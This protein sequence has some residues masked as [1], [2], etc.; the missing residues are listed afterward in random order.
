MSYSNLVLADRP[1]GY[2]SG[3]SFSRKNLLSQ[4]QYSLETSTAGWSALDNS[5]ISRV[6][7]DAWIGTASLQITPS[8]SSEAGFKIA[9]GS[10]VQLS[11]GRTYTM[12][13]RVKNTSGSRTARIRVE[14]FTTQSG[15][16]L[17]EPTRLGREFDISNSEWTTIYNTEII[18]T[19]TST[20]YFASWGIVSGPG[21]STDQ[22]LVDGIQF[23]EGPP[24]AIYDQQYNND[25][26]L[27]YL[28]YKN[29]KPIIFN[30]EPAI[31]LSKDAI[32]EIPNPYKLFISGAESKTA[33]VD[34]WFTLEKPPAYRHQLIKISQFISCYIENDKIYIDYLG[35]K[36]FVQINNWS[37]Q[38]YVNLVY[39]EKTIY[40]YVD[41]NLSTFIDLGSDFSFDRVSEFISPTVVIGPASEPVNKIDNPSFEQGVVGWASL[42]SSIQSISS[43]SFSG[44][45]CLEITKQSVNNSGVECSNLISVN[46]YS[47]YSLS[48]YIKIPS[49]EE[50][51]TL[52]LICEEYDSYS[53]NNLI[54]VSEE[55]LEILN[56]NWS[57]LSLSFVP[58]V[59]TVAV[60]IKIVQKSSGVESER[61]LCD[62]VLLEKSP[63][64]STWSETL[65]DSDPLFIS[66]IGLY[67]HDI[68]DQRRLDRFLYASFDNDDL[69][70]IE[71]GADRFSLNYSTALSESEI[72]VISSENVLNSSLNNIVYGETSLSTPLLSTE[73]VDIGTSG[74]DVV[75]NRKGIKFSGSAFLPL[76]Q[77]NNYLNP[78]SSTIRMQTLF[79]TTSGDGT[80][81]LIGGV[82]SSYGVALQKI[83]NKL[84]LVLISDPLENIQV[85]C[86]TT[87]LSN[88]LKNIAINLNNRMISLKVDSQEFLDIEIP[89][90]SSSGGLVVG[91]LPENSNAYPDY[92]RNFSV[93]ELTD[94]SNI[95]WVRTG[96]YM[97]RFNGSL[98]VSQR[99]DFQYSSPEMIPASNSI[100]SF[101]TSAQNEVYIN[102][103]FVKDVSNIPIFNY[104]DPEPVNISV[105]METSNSARDRKSLN[106]FYISTYN[107]DSILSSLSS[108]SLN[109]NYLQNAPYITNTVSSNVLSHDDN[110]GIKFDKTISSGCRIVAN[111]SS[112]SE[113]LEIVFKINSLPN[114]GEKYTIFDLDEVTNTGLKY[115]N[116]GLIKSGSFTTYLD[117]ELVNNIEDSEITIGEFYHLLVLFDSPNS[118]DICL[119][120]D[121][122]IQ[123]V[124]DGTIGKINIYTTA[125]QNITDFA[126]QKFLDLIG[127]PFKSLSGGTAS[128]SDTSA[129]QE[130][131]R[132]SLG[133]YYQM[134]NLPKVKIVSE[135]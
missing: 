64:S 73:N 77:V 23:F 84:R 92:I 104:S 93:D 96:R 51:S 88:G 47:K 62:A 67:S 129:S 95:D 8:S 13:A 110:L 58:T 105:I 29:C 128:V 17:S 83:S 26:E 9:P 132:D 31:R 52:T 40:M 115:S 98:N 91:N 113:L 123:D 16:T 85:L 102:E 109:K 4:N 6:T 24:Y 28:N 60:K 41:D 12:V 61:F 107:S 76:T 45:N 70:A 59:D 130:Y 39:S 119:G 33:S 74:G 7:T 2:W 50:L 89:A 1:L 101:N 44:S 27:R 20:N 34:F 15:L 36:N 112:T 10:R 63:V 82:L 32:I 114:S 111:N 19:G 103:K 30:G 106:N 97:L 56:N 42:N 90:I 11:Y 118:L 21:E 133:E 99:S 86:E 65:E 94:F 131:I 125:P 80:A 46:P 69:M 18:P 120:S 5:S 78:V 14:Y 134:K 37:R 35:R 38:H 87:T 48:A 72:N 55:Q 57:R 3:P 124:L 53:Q 126:E 81:L 100:V 68:G 66:S 49:G 127:V 122:N 22:I 117:G 135:I 121:K 79:E 54:N 25:A 71:Y 116:Q 43:D 75:L 108:F